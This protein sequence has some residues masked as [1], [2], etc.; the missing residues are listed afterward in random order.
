MSLEQ[1]EKGNRVRSEGENTIEIQF[2]CGTSATGLKRTEMP[3]M[4]YVKLET[5]SGSVPRIAT[6]AA[7]VPP[8]MNALVLNLHG[9]LLARSAPNGRLVLI[10]PRSLTFV[11][12]GRLVLQAARG[13]HESLLITW[14]AR[15]TPVLEIWLSG[16][17]GN[18]ANA[19][20]TVA[21]KPIDPHFQ[22]AY[23]RFNTAL[24]GPQEV[25]EPLVL[26]VLY[27][28]V[29]RLMSSGDQVQLAALPL[30]LPDTI[31]DLIVKVRKN[32]AAP[33]PLKDAA[34]MA[35]Y[36]PFHFSRVFKSL[37]GYGFHEFVDR[38][39]TECAVEMLV[40]TESAVDLVASTCGFGTTQGL[41]E[42]V[43]E[44][45]GLVPSELRAVPDAVDIG[46]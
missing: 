30:D 42:S 10:P 33:W 6:G 25:M 11:R 17:T 37:V 14:P 2:E 8:N 38:S 36:S 16:R 9:T 4:G 40:T 12:P 31:K 15:A 35:G 1:G 29:A 34:D 22:G 41:R 3:G 43:K 46:P 23:E 32:P 44:Y 21:C 20:R 26:S 19:A 13:D 45:L 27:E 24:K 7:Y 28:V 39:R 18:R 5:V